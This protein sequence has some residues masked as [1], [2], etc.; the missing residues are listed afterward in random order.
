MPSATEIKETHREK[1]IFGA[2]PG[3]TC[4]S[5][6]HSGGEDRRVSVSYVVTT[7]LGWVGVSSYASEFC[8]NDIG[9]LI[10]L[11]FVETGSHHITQA[12]HHPA[13][14]LSVRV[15]GVYPHTVVEGLRNLT[16]TDTG[17]L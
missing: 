13:S 3:G 4:L 12:S 8:F 10:L 1:G 17:V 5:S 15:T 9:I 7:C 14:A 16:S 11:C 6:Q 2:G